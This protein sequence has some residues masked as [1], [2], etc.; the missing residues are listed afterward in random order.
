MDC[1]TPGFPVP[2]LSSG[3]SPNL[4]P[5]SQWCPSII[6]SSATPFFSCPQSFP[7]SGP[8]PMSWLFTPGGHSIGASASVSVLPV[9]VQRW[10]PLELTGLISL[11][12][13]DLSR[14]FSSTTIQKHQLGKKVLKCWI[15]GNKLYQC[16]YLHE[17]DSYTN[18]SYSQNL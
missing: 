1:C 5:L 14:V 10:F 16:W 17:M 3:F 13:K 15:I 7:A 11:Q 2:S 12:S 8:F 9:C 4:C 6:S 18:N